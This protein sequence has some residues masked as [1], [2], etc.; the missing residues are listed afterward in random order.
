MSVVALLLGVLLIC[1]VLWATR[2]LLTAFKVEDPIATVV[3]V[4]VVILVLM[5][6]L[7]GTVFPGKLHL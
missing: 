1:V 5:A 7:G 3:F 6:L 2:A 4:I